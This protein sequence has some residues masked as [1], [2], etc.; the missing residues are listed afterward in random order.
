MA[1]ATSWSMD[2]RC[3]GLPARARPARRL[4]ML[5][6]WSGQTPEYVQRARLQR[7]MWPPRPSATA[8]SSW[9]RELS[10]T[11]WGCSHD[12]TTVQSLIRDRFANDVE[13]R[14]SRLRRC[15][16]V[17]SAYSSKAV[18]NYF[19]EK[20]DLP[21]KGRLTQ[22]KLHKLVYFAHGICLAVYNKPLIKDEIQA[23]QYGPVVPELVS[24][25]KVPC[26]T[27]AANFKNMIYSL[28]F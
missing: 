3:L 5:L 26:Q 28:C 6:L 18:A 2:P 11:G 25:R 21:A 17:H 13:T 10:R 20:S 16:N 4:P 19:L 27:V 12:A 9:W 22:M 14:Y 24:A 15:Q 7:Q 23:W 1:P 8:N